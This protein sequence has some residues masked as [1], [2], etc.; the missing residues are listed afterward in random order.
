MGAW[1]LREGNQ[2]D[3]E[4]T[5][6][7]RETMISEMTVE[8]V[9]DYIDIMTDALAAQNDNFTLRMN[10]KDT[11]EVFSVTRRDGV[12]LSY[13]GETDAKPDCTVTCARLQLIALMNGNTDVIEKM[14]VEGDATV[15][16][17]MVQ[18]MSPINKVFNII[19]P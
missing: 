18:Y 7:G 15:M 11:G 5:V 12:L 19:E 14:Q 8:M 1:E 2:A 3:K 9:L 13:K 16:T 4:A 10:V 6:K 17:R